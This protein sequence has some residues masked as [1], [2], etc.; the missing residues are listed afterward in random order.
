MEFGDWMSSEV[1]DAALRFLEP[2]VKVAV[3]DGKAQS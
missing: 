1:W 3:C 2:E